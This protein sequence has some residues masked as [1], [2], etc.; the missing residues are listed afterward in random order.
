MRSM[1]RCQ[2]WRL[3][4]P[5]ADLEQSTGTI[6]CFRREFRRALLAFAARAASVLAEAAEE[7]VS[8][9]TVFPFG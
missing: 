4:V 1:R 3:G 9:K 5:V 7:N 2:S 6:R 8:P